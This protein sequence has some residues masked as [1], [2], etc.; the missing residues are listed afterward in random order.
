MQLRFLVSWFNERETRNQKPETDFEP[1]FNDIRFLY[2]IFFLLAP[3]VVTGVLYANRP[4]RRGAALFSSVADLRG[5]PVTFAQRVRRLMPYAQMLGLLLIVA[6]LARPQ[7]GVA[8]SR[9]R[10]E[11]IAIETVLDISGSMEA[12]DFE[13]DGKSV[14]RLVAVQHVVKKFVQGSSQGKLAGRPNDLVG[15]VAFGGFA[16]SRCP[17]T[18]DHGAVLD[19]VASLQVP[20]RIYDRRGK[21]LN[22]EDYAT[23]I[24]DGVALGIER[25][26]SVS[27]K[28]KVLILLTDGDNTAGETDPRTSAKAAQSLGIRIYTIGV[29]TS[30]W[31]RVPV[32]DVFGKRHYETTNQFRIDEE[33]LKEMAQ[34]AGGKYFRASNSQGLAEIY[35]EIDALERTEVEEVK[36]TEYTEL[37][38]WLLTPGAILVAC[39][40]FLRATRFRSL[41]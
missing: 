10:S 7:M 16:D 2:P 22:M 39:V 8:N 26:N 32:T 35:A 25:L 9:V 13:I 15:L 23:A 33:L 1:M 5:L 4:A 24:G 20:Q 3:A 17:L 18:L 21:V 38:A 37:F 6:A 36:F 29:G 11:G 19:A 12:E 34:T 14:N 40:G 30:G 27:A 31:V 28:S 41:P